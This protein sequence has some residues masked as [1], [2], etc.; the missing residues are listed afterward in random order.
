MALDCSKIFPKLEMDV[1]VIPTLLLSEDALVKTQQFAAPKYVGDPLNA[2]R[3]FNEK[4][5]DELI[6]LDIGATAQGTGPNFGLIADI[7]TECFM[8]MSYG[9]G[10]SSMKQAA[11]IL[12]SGVEKVVMNTALSRN[13][14]LIEECAR[15]FGSQ[16]VVAS[17]DYRRNLLGKYV[18]HNRAD[19]NSDPIVMARRAEAL[20]AGELIVTAVNREGTG[21]GYDLELIQKVSAAVNIPVIANGGAGS[22]IDFRRAVDAGA[23]AVAA[24]SMFVFHGKHRSVLITYPDRYDLE[25][26]MQ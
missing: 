20:G 13:P 25:K 16:A 11:T 19:D 6:I 18:L 14:N 9:G 12:A 23:S 1:R 5:V 26:I 8:P 21:K 24:G 10:I 4:F 17:L 15:E 3:T 7:A 22:L 2:V